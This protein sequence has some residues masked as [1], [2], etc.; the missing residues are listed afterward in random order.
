MVKKWLVWAILVLLALPLHG[1]ILTLIKLSDSLLFTHELNDTVGVMNYVDSVLNFKS[2]G[3][4]NVKAELELEA[5]VSDQLLLNITKAYF[6]AR[7][8][9]FRLTM[10]KTR[11]SWGEGFLF[12]AGDLIFDGLSFPSAIS[13][14]DLRIETDYMAVLYFPLGRFSYFETVYLPK[15]VMV[16]MDPSPS[17]EFYMPASVD[18]GST[19]AGGR[20]QF[21]I[22][23]TKLEFGYL[24]KGALRS[25]N[26]FVSLQ[27]NL[28]VDWNLSASCAIN[29][30]NAD[31]EL[32]KQSLGVSF[33]LFSQFGLGSDSSLTLR[34]ES[35]IKPFQR[36]EEDPSPPA[37]PAM[38]SYALYLFPD[39]TFAIDSSLSLQLR[40]L[41]SPCDASAMIFGGAGWNPYQGLTFNFYA[42]AMAGDSNDI[43]GWGREKD[44]FIM[45]ETQFLFGTELGE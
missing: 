38:P 27:G 17:S 42:G 23:R 26:A 6:K 14:G 41:I 18:I 29:Q 1:E 2:A 13:T 3:N 25:H 37:F 35:A 16:D 28:L 30:D 40:S 8:P 31:P 33:G 11:V 44:F 36:W 7:F 9:V 20:F 19:E 39:I 32:I 5:T 21:D 15:P 34:L 10:G 4:R 22:A 12:N 45:L 24:Y 43:F